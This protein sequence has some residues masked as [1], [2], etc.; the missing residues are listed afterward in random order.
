[1]TKELSPLTKYIYYIQHK[2]DSLDDTV[3]QLNISTI[4]NISEDDVLSCIYLDQLINTN[5]ILARNV[6]FDKLSEFHRYIN[7][8]KQIQ[9]M[10]NKSKKTTDE[11]NQ[12][13]QQHP[14]LSEEDIKTYLTLTKNNTESL[15]QESVVSSNT[16]DT[17]DTISPLKDE[18]EKR[19]I[20]QCALCKS[21]NKDD[22]QRTIFDFTTNDIS[23]VKVLFVGEAPAVNEIKEGKPFVGRAGQ[24]LRR[25]LDN[26]GFDDIHWGVMNV[27]LCFHQPSNPPMK[28][29]IAYCFDNLELIISKL[30]A[31]AVIVPLGNYPCSR[32]G[33]T[34]KI[35]D[36]MTKI[37]KYN[38][39]LVL[40]CI[41]PSA[42]CRNMS[43]YDMFANRLKQIRY[44][45]ES[46]DNVQPHMS[47]TTDDVRKLFPIPNK[48]E[49]ETVNNN[50][51]DTDTTSNTSDN[52]M[53]V[54]TVYNY[55]KS[56]VNYVL[57]RGQDKIIH[58]TDDKYALYYG[59]SNNTVEYKNK[60]K[61]KVIQ[62]KD[63]VNVIN[64]LKSKGFNVFGDMNLS[65]YKNIQFRNTYTETEQPLR[66]A[67]IDIELFLNGNMM[68]LDDMMAAAKR[69]AISLITL[70][71]SYTDTYYTF[72]NNS[73]NLNIDKQ[74]IIKHLEYKD[75]CNIEIFVYNDE[76]KMLNGFIQKFDEIDPDLVTGWNSSA[77]DWPF[78]INRSQYLGIEC[79]NK[80]GR[81]FI[82]ERTNK[83]Y[84][85]YVV[86]CDYLTLYK[87][88]TFSKRES[89]TL[90]FIAE[91]ELGIKKLSLDKRFD[92]MWL[93][94]P[95]RFIAYNIN[96]VHLVRKLD[97]K[98]KYIDIQFNIIRATNISWEES[99]S[100]LPIIDGILFTTLDKQNKTVICKKY[101]YDKDN[102]QKTEK[103]KGAFVRKPLKGLYNWLAD[104]DLSSLYPYIIARYNISIDTYVGKVDEYIAREYIYNRDELLSQPDRLI[105][106]EDKNLN[107]KQITV[108]KLHETITKYNLI[109]TIMGTMYV[110]HNTKLSVYYEIIDMLIRERKRYKNEMFKAIEN[111]N[112]MLAERY[113]NWQFTYKVLTNSLYGGIANQYFRLFHF[114]SAETITASGREIVTMGAYHIHQYLNKMRDAHK[115]DIEPYEFD[116]RFLDADVLENIVYGDSVD[117]NTKINTEQYP[118]GIPIKDLFERHKEYKLMN[119]IGREYIF[120]NDKVLTYEDSDVVYKPINNMSRH[121]VNKPMYRIRTESGKELIVTEDHSIMVERDGKLIQVKPNEILD[122]DLVLTNQKS[123]T[124]RL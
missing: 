41:H 85:P 61:L 82:N 121:K 5:P 58:T 3:K 1:M 65:V 7:R 43:R 92:D 95:N 100:T 14:Y 53:L 22:I 9:F 72:I 4:L 81:I 37:Y 52:I 31:D 91:F 89:Y 122:S 113:N 93:S 102:D 25:T 108:Q 106:Y 39:L 111:N 115:M 64:D 109:I 74:E 21:N 104:L 69:Y 24:L 103:L 117:E 50:K 60:L 87:K 47:Y 120:A 99:F 8:S 107:V 28:N 116:T 23:Q 49:P 70:Y 78:I 68:L 12:L 101:E 80:Y 32:F 88:R 10:S 26:T 75:E 45:I 29:E 40:P 118:D 123:T 94:D 51:N 77:F 98:L 66:I 13:K 97:N 59:K 36:A 33:I 27:C 62:F 42:I 44:A 114:P 15:N 48:T 119:Y 18:I 20:T 90:G 124:H 2:T 67:A 11:I 112:H 71:D 84:I 38:E 6:P 19:L 46:K 76:R 83:P 35:T 79:K 57:R 34:D 86:E 17:I 96:D 105:N 30:P 16:E 56:E 54:N 55:L 110:N 73:F 63:R